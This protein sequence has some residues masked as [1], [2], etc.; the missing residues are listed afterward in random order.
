MTNSSQ[1]KNIARA[2][3]TSHKRSSL[4][5]GVLI[6]AIGIILIVCNK[7]ISG[8][9]IIVLAG[10][11]FILTGIINLI[12]FVTRKTADGLPINSGFNLFIGWLVSIAAIILG[13]CMLVFTPTFTALVPYIFGILIFFGALVLAYAF[14]F[15]VRKQFKIPGWLWI[16]PLAILILGIVVITRSHIGNDSLIMILS[17]SAMITFGF[18]A[19][20][21]SALLAGARRQA[22]LDGIAQKDSEPEIETKDVEAKDVKQIN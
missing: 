3:S 6:L 13:I 9:G 11:L 15:G 18:G 10:I 16:F 2:T 17:G 1:T 7:M 5:A 14:I 20:I 22:R 21:V 8:S 19:V 12:V 4:L